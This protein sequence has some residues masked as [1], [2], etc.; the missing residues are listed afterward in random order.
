MGTVRAEG[1][2]VPGDLSVIGFDGT[3]VG[4]FC[5]PPLSTIRQPTAK[6][7]AKAAQILMRLLDGDTA[8]L[9][10]RT[11]LPNQLLLRASTAAPRGGRGATVAG[12]PPSS[13]A[14]RGPK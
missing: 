3:P 11:V 10:L 2:A 5:E 4:A 1:V 12:P 14:R 8:G 9:P 7:G 13:R 6:L